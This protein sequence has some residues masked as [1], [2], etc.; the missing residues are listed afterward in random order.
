MAQE[1]QQILLRV[2]ED[3]KEAGLQHNHVRKA[4]IFEKLGQI[5]ALMELSKKAERKLKKAISNDAVRSADT[6]YLD[7]VVASQRCFLIL[8][9]I[10][11]C[12]GAKKTDESITRVTVQAD[13]KSTPLQ[14]PPGKEQPTPP[15]RGP[16]TPPVAS[17]F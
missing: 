16:I 9:E 11:R 4:C 1:Q 13:P 14:N 6:A 2:Q 3:Y 5:K 17:D 8:A 10:D 12:G 7:I 15:S